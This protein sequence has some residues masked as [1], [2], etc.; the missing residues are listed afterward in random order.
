MDGSQWLIAGTVPGPAFPLFL[1][2]AVS[3][4]RFLVLG[5]E[6]VPVVR[7]TPALYA[8]CACT[9]A[10]TGAAVPRLMLAGDT[11][12]GA[13]SRALYAELVRLLPGLSPAGIT[14]HYLYPDVDAQ[15]RILMA[16][17]A[18]ERPPVLVADAGYMYAAKM[19]G[20]AARYHVFTPDLGELA[21]LADEKAPHP[22]Y[23]RGFLLA[24]EKDVCGLAARACAH[25]NAA[26]WLLIKGEADSVVCGGK[27]MALSLIHI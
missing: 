20:Y 22:F 5:G 25:G 9:C 1:G 17:D 27:L 2:N 19:S 21:F 15:N 11:G 26:Q 13:G 18:L 3:D 8:A 7:G 16:V 14:F 23:T 4:G 10:T 12:N 6:K 24:E